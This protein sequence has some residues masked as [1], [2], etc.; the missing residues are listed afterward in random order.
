MSKLLPKPAGGPKI[1]TKED[2]KTLKARRKLEKKEAKVRAKQQ[3]REDKE[4]KKKEKKVAGK[5][6]GGLIDAP[7]LPPLPPK[8][9]ASGRRGRR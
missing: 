1:T 9:T 7:L 3:T 6:L 8:A 5:Q 2:R 4:R